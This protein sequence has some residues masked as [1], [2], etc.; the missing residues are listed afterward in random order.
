M[1]TDLGRTLGLGGAYFPNVCFSPVCIFEKIFFTAPIFSQ[2]WPA[3]FTHLCGLPQYFPD[4]FP[5]VYQY[6]P[7]MS[8]WCNLLPK[9]LGKCAAP[10]IGKIL[11]KYAETPVFLH[12][13]PICSFPRVC[14]FSQYF[15][16]RSPPACIFSAYFPNLW[17]GVLGIVSQYWLAYFTNLCG[18]PQYFPD[19]FPIVYQYFPNMSSW[20]NLLPKK[21]GKCAAPNIGKILAKY[22]ETPVFLH[23]LPK[24]SFPRVCTFSQYFSARSP[25]ACIFSAYF[26]NLWAGVLGIV[27]QYWL[28]YFTHLCG[29]PQYFPDVFPIV[30]QYCPDMSSWCNLLPKKLGK[31]AAPNI[32]KILAKYAETPVFLHILP[33]CSFPR[34]CIFSQ[35][36][37]ARSPPACI[38]SAYFPNLWAGVLGIVSQYWLAYFTHLCGLPQYFP[39][40]FPT[41]YQYFPDM[42]SWCNLLPKRLGKC[43][44][45]NIGKILAKYAETPVFLHILP[46]C[47]FPRVCIFSQYFSARSPPVCIFSQSLGRRIGKLLALE[48]HPKKY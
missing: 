38:F 11:A 27:S 22:A 1:T 33:I 31:C 23:I 21:L 42:S 47:S 43:A 19:V 3:Y 2:Y 16:A 26:P 37:S 18:L 13:L 25:P 45:P 29:L 8:S 17:A 30:Y 39:D 12:I 5:I 35:Y 41:V 24:G 9:R 14:I 32:G 6:C 15:S 46:I 28:A 40:V 10:N 36:F 4:V 20:F 48:R 7:D 44:A 34:V